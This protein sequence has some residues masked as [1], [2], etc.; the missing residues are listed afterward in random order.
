MA[1]WIRN[2]WLNY[3]DRV[4]S[5]FRVY[6][7]SSSV[8][9]NRDG[10]PNYDVSCGKCRT[11][12]VK[13]HSE[14]SNGANGAMLFCCIPSCPAA[15]VTNPESDSLAD[16]RRQEREQHKQ[17]ERE[18]AARRAEATQKA[19]KERAECANKS[20]WRILANV[21]FKSGIEVDSPE[22]VS[23]SRWQSWSPAFQSEILRKVQGLDNGI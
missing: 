12:Q 19:E 9:A 14:L 22:W 2:K 7:V 10:S 4:V 15:K 23:F 1:T 16:L 20:R 6:G 21:Q 5:G 8:L 18:Q 13:S 17:A 11:V 3:E